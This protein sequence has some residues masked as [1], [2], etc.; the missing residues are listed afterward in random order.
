[1]NLTRLTVIALACVLAGCGPANYIMMTE[2]MAP[3]IEKGD[4][5]AIDMAAYRQEAP[6]IGDIVAYHA[7]DDRKGKLLMGRVVALAGDTVRVEE[8]SLH[9]N[10]EP[11]EEPYVSGEVSYDVEETAVP[12][13]HI[14]I[15][16]DNR[17]EARDSRAFGPVPPEHVSGRIVDVQKPPGSE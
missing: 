5:M 9:R 3:A 17:D 10:S 4:I 13:G 11:V 2:S 7:P 6:A 15:L 12:E 8:G 1:M 14:Y 16:G